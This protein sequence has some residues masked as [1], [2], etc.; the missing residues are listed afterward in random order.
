M[1]PELV[2]EEWVAGEGQPQHVEESSSASSGTL[3]CATYVKQVWQGMRL[4]RSGSA[5]SQRASN[6]SSRTGLCLEGMRE[7]LLCSI[8]FFFLS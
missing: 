2:L 7:V 8:A 5:R 6:A 1:A 4:K 3:C